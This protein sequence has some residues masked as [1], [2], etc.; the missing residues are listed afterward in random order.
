MIC[1]SGD[2]IRVREEWD[3]T[4]KNDQLKIQNRQ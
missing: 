4:M 1:L 2:E 3:K